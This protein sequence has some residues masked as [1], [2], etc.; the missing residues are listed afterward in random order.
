M[1]AFSIALLVIAGLCWVPLLINYVYRCFKNFR[2]L[3]CYQNQMDKKIKR[4]QIITAVTDEMFRFLFLSMVAFLLVA[5]WFQ[6]WMWKMAASLQETE[7]R[8]GSETEP[9][10]PVPVP[11]VPEPVPEFDP[12]FDPEPECMPDPVIGA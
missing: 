7:C 12:E 2:L 1:D 9:D 10:V 5:I 4:L 11:D 8:T 6:P 3:T